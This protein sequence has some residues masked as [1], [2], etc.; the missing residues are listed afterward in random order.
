MIGS[1]LIHHTLRDLAK[2]YGP[3]MYLKI[4]EVPTI[5]I[6]SPEF[7]KQ[8]MRVHDVNFA[9]RPSILFSKIM[10]YDGAGLAFAPYGEHWRQVRKI[11]MQELLNTTR[12]QSFNYIREEE[13]LN[14]VDSISSNVGNM[15]RSKPKLERLRER[16]A[17]IFEEIIHEH[18]KQKPKERSDEDFVDVLLK[19][20]HDND[21]LGFSL[22][23]ENIY[24]I[25]FEIFGAGVE[26][27][28]SSVEWVMS[29]LMKNPK[30]MK[31]A[32]DEVREVFRRKGLGNERALDEM[33]YLKSV[34]KES[35]RLHPILPLIVPRQNQ[36]KCEINGYEIPAKTNTIINAWVIGRDSNYWPEPE[37]FKP[38]R[39]LD[40]SNCI[41]S[42]LGNNFEYLPF[43]GGRR[44]CV[45]MSFGLLSVEL[46]LALLLYHFDWMLPN[47]MKN[48]DLDMTESFRATLQRKNFLQVIPII[49][50]LST[51]TANK[52]E[53]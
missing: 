44:I 41:D 14:F 1:S 51:S 23:N 21:D 48:E 11:F 2:K 43:G 10:L 38:E 30:I 8:V 28:A 39:F 35:M 42:K 19:Y 4:G 34:I 27:S 22:T 7:A 9:S 53:L 5:V 20:H 24:A 40:D 45:G 31:K 25:I 3:L 32:Q 52:E 36:E 12:V 46:S 50:E 18:K 37:I 29:E 26:T 49:Q 13:M 33:K 6:S 15:S 47:G 17:K 16:T